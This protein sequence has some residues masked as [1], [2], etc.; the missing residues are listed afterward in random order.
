MGASAWRYYVP[1]QEDINQALQDLRAS[2]FKSGQYYKPQPTAPPAPPPATI[3]DLLEA[4]AESGSHSILDVPMVSPQPDLGAVAPLTPDELRQ[5]FGTE[6]P[7]R[8]TL[9]RNFPAVY[10]ITSQRGAWAGT[11][12][13][14]YADDQPAEIFFF[15]Q[16]GD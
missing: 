13:V 3:E 5:Y 12:L 10:D 2:V 11:Y 8:E 7:T 16:S 1:Y 4:N 14:V 9:E 6:R 15:G